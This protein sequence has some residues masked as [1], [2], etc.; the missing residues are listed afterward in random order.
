MTLDGDQGS[1]DLE[2]QVSGRGF[3]FFEPIPADPHSGGIQ[4][5]ESSSA[6][7]PGVWLKANDPENESM[8]HLSFDGCRQLIEQLQ[9]FTDNHYQVRAK[10]EGYDGR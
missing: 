9:W 10:S 8:V 1:N 7:F 6:S 2:V 4:L 5:L 3:R